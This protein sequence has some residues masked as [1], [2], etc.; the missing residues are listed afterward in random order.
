MHYTSHPAHGR[1]DLRASSEDSSSVT[2]RGGKPA[3]GVWSCSITSP[4]ALATL[5]P[6][7]T[8][9]S[10]GA[11]EQIKA[12]AKQYSHL[13][14]ERGQVGC[15]LVRHVPD[16]KGLRWELSGSGPPVP[17]QQVVLERR[18]S[19]AHDPGFS[20]Q[21]LFGKDTFLPLLFSPLAA[22]HLLLIPLLFPSVDLTFTF[23]REMLQ[24]PILHCD[25]LSHF[26]AEPHVTEIKE[27]SL[28][29]GW[30]LT[31]HWQQLPLR[32]YHNTFDP[33]KHGY[34]WAKQKKQ[35]KTK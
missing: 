19:I 4:L 25:S 14:E 12:F 8:L 1:A 7:P 33:T 32:K 30:H 17:Q 2:Y 35:N 24:N 15:N 27:K 6:S 28:S 13:E 23:H 26:C 10:W 11:S 16:W 9:R 18:G 22:K 5:W 29:E 20:I 3:V 31:P 34:I 21:C